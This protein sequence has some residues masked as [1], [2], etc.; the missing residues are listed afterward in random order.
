MISFD[1]DVLQGYYLAR[2]PTEEDLLA[3]L[4][5]EAAGSAAVLDPVRSSAFTS[6]VARPS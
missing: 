4:A 5:D 2:P 6:A 1:F 3:M